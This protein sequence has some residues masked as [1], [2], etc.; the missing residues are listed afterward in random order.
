MEIDDVSDGDLSAQ[1]RALHGLKVLEA[2]SQLP[3]KTENECTV[4]TSKGL[5]FP[6]LPLDPSPPDPQL[7]LL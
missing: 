2:L 7:Q 3:I 4:F 6:S 1:Y 5:F